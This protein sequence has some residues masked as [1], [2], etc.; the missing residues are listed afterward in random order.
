MSERIGHFKS[1]GPV[2]SRTL[3]TAWCPRTEKVASLRT[4]EGRARSMRRA[5]ARSTSDQGDAG[6]TGALLRTYA[7]PEAAAPAK[8]MAMANN[9]L[10][11]P[12]RC[13]VVPPSKAEEVEDLVGHRR[14]QRH[15]VNGVRAAGD[16]VGIGEVGHALVDPSE[17]RVPPQP[18]HVLAPVAEGIGAGDGD[19][20]PGGAPAAH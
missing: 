15:L 17:L 19:Q 20:G 11:R 5:P 12:P 6:R 10:S 3:R 18:G 14:R 16:V 1:T 13:S 2:G 4:A 9:V 7:V 8:A